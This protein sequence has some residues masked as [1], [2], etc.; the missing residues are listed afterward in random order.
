MPLGGGGLG[1][2][3]WVENS[4]KQPRCCYDVLSYTGLQTTFFYML[5]KKE[6]STTTTASSNWG[7]Y[8]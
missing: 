5:P 2:N 3:V 6:L 7:A 4:K 8:V 1:V